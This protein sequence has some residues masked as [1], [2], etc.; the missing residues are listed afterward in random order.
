MMTCDDPEGVRVNAVSVDGWCSR[1][2]DAR[3]DHQ[4]FSERRPHSPTIVRINAS[5]HIFLPSSFSKVL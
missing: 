4:P 1:E 3:M 2:S 5:D